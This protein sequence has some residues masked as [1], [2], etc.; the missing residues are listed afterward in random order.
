MGGGTL[1]CDF[2]PSWR[3]IVFRQPGILIDLVQMV[4]CRLEDGPAQGGHRGYQSLGQRDGRTNSLS[5]SQ[6]FDRIEAV[7]DVGYIG[8]TILVG[9]R[10]RTR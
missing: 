4:L 6:L 2:L 7:G 10:S 9:G 1:R 8:F 5:P 3:G